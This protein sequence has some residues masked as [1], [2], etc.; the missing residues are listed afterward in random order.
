MKRLVAFLTVAASLAVPA[1]AQAAP[2]IARPNPAVYPVTLDYVSPVPGPNGGPATLPPVKRGIIVAATRDQAYLAFEVRGDLGGFVPAEIGMH[3]LSSGGRSVL[4]PGIHEAQIPLFSQAAGGR[5]SSFTFT[6]TPPTPPWPPDNGKRPVPGIGPPPPVPAP[7]AAAVPPANQGFGGRPNGG[8]RGGAPTTPTTG[9]GGGG[10]GGGTTTR[11]EPPLTTTATTTTIG[12]TQATETTTAT[13]TTAAA[14]SGGG[15]SGGGGSGGCSGGSCSAG[16]CG[17]PGIAVDS[18]APGCVIA[19]SGA[20][21]GDSVFATFTVTNTTGAPF[22]LSV[23]AD[24]AP[25]NHLRGDLELGVWDASAAPPVVLPPLTSWL[26]GYS[27]LTTLNAGQSVHYVVELF[28][29]TSVGNA[30]QGESISITFRWH[31][32][33]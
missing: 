26:A 8:G 5:I 2:P 20:A 9:G 24:A 27:P 3:A 11:P 30:D 14:G 25:D 4:L 31:A 6:G 33:G 12:A 22:A 15:G 19:I 28:L 32:Q 23:K 7:G 17:V 18:T 1:L 10:G 13:V 21:P 16:G 29:P